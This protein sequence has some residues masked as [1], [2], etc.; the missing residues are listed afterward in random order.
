[1]KSK[2]PAMSKKSIPFEKNL[3]FIKTALENSLSD[4][5]VKAELSK[6]GY[7]EEKIKEG[8]KLFTEA[9]ALAFS[10]KK[11]YSEQIKA[12]KNFN[13]AWDAAREM[14]YVASKTAQ[15]AFKNNPDAKKLL[16]LDAERK[17][18]ISG[19]LSQTNLFYSNLIS[20]NDLINEISKYGYSKE[21]LESKFKVC[22]NVS[23]LNIIQAK[24]SGEAQD[25]TKVRDDKIDELFSW[26]S[27]FKKIAKLA[28]R[29]HPQWLEKIGFE[30]IE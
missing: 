28:L 11:E 6:F 17:Q 12:T 16:G 9:E 3:H 1:M 20:S 19:W 4:E 5:S 23:S 22:E 18:S 2:G 30:G 27:D 7:T 26:I 29:A 14:Y 13:D 24:E 8:K 21:K 10:Q 25:S 15:V